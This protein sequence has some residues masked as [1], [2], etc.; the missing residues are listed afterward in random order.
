MPGCWQLLG[1]WPLLRYCQYLELL[2]ESSLGQHPDTVLPAGEEGGA[3]VLD[4]SPSGGTLSNMNTCRKGHRTGEARTGMSGQKG[5]L[6]WGEGARAL[7]FPA[8]PSCLACCTLIPQCQARTHTGGGCG[9]QSPVSASPQLDS[10][11]AEPNFD[12]DG[13]DEYNELHMPV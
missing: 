9:L 11:D 13:R 6:L 12:E 1:R 7:L 5:G 8:Q 2:L 4:Q 10:E 3:A